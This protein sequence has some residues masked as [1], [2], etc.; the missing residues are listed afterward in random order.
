MKKAAIKFDDLPPEALVRL[1]TKS[2]VLG[3]SP[4]TIWRRIKAGELPKPVKQGLRV[5]AWSKRE[6]LEVLKAISSGTDSAAMKKLVAKLEG[7]RV[8]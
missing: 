5:S 7:E 1:P 4:A 8:K 3:I 6:I 2:A